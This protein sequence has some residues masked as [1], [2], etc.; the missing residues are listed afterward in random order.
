MGGTVI[1]EEG[2]RLETLGVTSPPSMNSLLSVSSGSS[3][4]SPF[5]RPHSKGRAS[6]QPAT[7][8]V[9][10]PTPADPTRPGARRKQS[11]PAT[12]PATATSSFGSTLQP[13]SFDEK[14]Q[15]EVRRS[16]RRTGATS[17]TP[18]LGAMA[19]NTKE[20]PATA[21]TFAAGG[22]AYNAHRDNR[23]SPSAS[24]LPPDPLQDRPLTRK[25]SSTSS[26]YS[27]VSSIG[28]P[29][30]K[31]SVPKGAAKAE[32]VLGLAG[33]PLGSDGTPDPDRVSCL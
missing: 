4:P 8:T 6:T 22:S 9:V 28:L 21:E 32:K 15:D 3:N 2:R 27:I 33:R 1:L 5:G 26:S 20:R 10:P 16:I 17:S 13:L 31:M 30:E 24:L 23:S 11:A 29:E 25:R 18:D 7:P 12:S 14:T 19:R